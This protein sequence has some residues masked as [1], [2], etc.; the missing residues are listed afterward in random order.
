[1]SRSDRRADPPAYASAMPHRPIAEFRADRAKGQERLLDTEHLGIKRFLNLD[2]ACYRDATDKGG[3][4][5]R[6]KELLGL[7]ASTVLRC[8]DCID[9]H[10]EQCIACGHT[11]TQIEDALNVALV[12]ASFILVTAIKIARI[13]IIE[14]QTHKA[15]ASRTRPISGKP[16]AA[17]RTEVIED[18]PVGS[19]R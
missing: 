19:P 13:K 6:T 12:V 1:M 15:A 5:T 16:S 17:P 18:E 10:L 14:E 2:T 7:I 9:Y 3:L 11:D 8:N 4:D